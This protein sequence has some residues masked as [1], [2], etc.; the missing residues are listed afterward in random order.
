MSSNEKLLLV[1]NLTT[2]FDLY[3]LPRTSP[4]R[5]LN[6]PN[7]K[8]YVKNGT[9]TEGNTRAVCGSDHGKIYVFDLATEEPVQVLQHGSRQ[10][11]IQSVEV[12]RSTNNS[13]IL[14]WVFS[15]EVIII[16]T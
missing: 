12:S 16:A 3:S 1:D 14:Q 8:K 10:D 7:S 13:Y 2:G 9:F 4:H 6:I 5:S 15:V 11:M